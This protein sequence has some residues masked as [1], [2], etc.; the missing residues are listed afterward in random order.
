MAIQ[1]LVRDHF[2]LSP[3]GIIRDLRLRRPIYRATAAYGHMGRTDIDAP[4]EETNKAD[5]LR[6]AAEKLGGLKKAETQPA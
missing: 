4:W 1:K 6:K 5:E 2:D 3:H